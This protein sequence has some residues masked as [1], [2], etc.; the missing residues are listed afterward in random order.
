M[1]KISL[2]GLAASKGVAEGVV[3][4]IARHGGNEDIE[5]GGVL[6]TEMTEP[7]MV[8]LM[9]KA[10]AIVT[11]V[12]GLTSHAA[13]VSRELGIPCVTATKEATAKL[14]DGMRVRVDGT[15]GTVSEL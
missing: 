5:E 11:D 4:V 14:K 12:G 3:K 1:D 6:V 7:A 13:I 9:N 2:T 15:S 8:I 10:A